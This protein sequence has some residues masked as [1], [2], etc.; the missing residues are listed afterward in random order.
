MYPNVD[1]PAW[2]LT[3][4][5]RETRTAKRGVEREV[6]P[7]MVIMPPCRMGM[8]DPYIDTSGTARL[9]LTKNDEGGRLRADVLRYEL[10][11]AD[12]HDGCGYTR[13][14]P[15]PDVKTAL[16]AVSVPPVMQPSS[17]GVA[18]PGSTV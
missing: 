3:W 2:R 17:K 5:R 11:A 4:L 12:C 10:T 9:V 18:K 6:P 15:P 7:P 16:T 8:P 14:N 1:P 13:L